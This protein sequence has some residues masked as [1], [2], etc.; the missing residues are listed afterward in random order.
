MQFDSANPSSRFDRR[1]LAKQIEGLLREF[2]QADDLA[3][4]GLVG[5]LVFADQRQVLPLPFALQ[6][7][8]TGVNATVELVYIHSIDALLE[9]VTQP[10]S[11][12]S[13]PRGAASHHHG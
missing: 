9:P 5:V 10:E 3:E 12:G 4:V 2:K 7:K 6:D 8:E 13:P 1:P 11:A